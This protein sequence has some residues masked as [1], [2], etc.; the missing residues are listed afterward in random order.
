VRRCR[1]AAAATSLT[2]LPH[3]LII[4]PSPLLRGGWPKHKRRQRAGGELAAYVQ[5]LKAPLAYIR[6]TIVAGSVGVRPS[7]LP[8][9]WTA[10]AR[11]PD[12][13]TVTVSSGFES[14][15]AAASAA[16]LALLALNGAVA[17]VER[18]LNRPLSSYAPSQRVQR[19]GGELAD[20]LLS[21]KPA[22]EVAAAA[23]RGG[24]LRGAKGRLAIPMGRRDARELQEEAQLLAPR[25]EGGGGG[26]GG[27]RAAGGGDAAAMS[28]GDGSDDDDWRGMPRRFG[29]DRDAEGGDLAGVAAAAAGAGGGGEWDVEACGRCAACLQPWRRQPCEAARASGRCGPALARVQKAVHARHATARRLQQQEEARQREH[30]AR[31]AFADPAGTVAVRPMARLLPPPAGGLQPPP[32]AL[33]MARQ[34]DEARAAGAGATGAGAT[35]AAGEVPLEALAEAVAAAAASRRPFVLV[36]ASTS[37]LSHCG[38][39]G[40]HS[41]FRAQC[42]AARALLAPAA[43][44][45]SAEAAGAPHW[46]SRLAPSA[47]DVLRELARVAAAAAAAGGAARTPSAA[48]DGAA[49]LPPEALL[50]A[51]VLVEELLMAGGGG[52]VV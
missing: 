14:W 22:A 4:A 21:L 29:R 23:A 33:P 13:R 35:S 49:P 48:A 30:L 27:R 46:L 15:D 39:C 34:L 20:Y 5:S 26:G 50:A 28:G 6:T 16:D 9:R 1:R 40:Q 38:F 24:R 44:L 25:G 8:G 11:A 45:P 52:G 31:L 32:A 12:G 36:G 10:K 3:H 37:S 43:P 42:P 51:A 41:H 47:R 17:G 19:A 18:Y 7:P 2:R